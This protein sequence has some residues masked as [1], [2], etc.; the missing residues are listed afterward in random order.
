MYVNY[1]VAGAGV[2]GRAACSGPWSRT[3]HLAVAVA[4]EGE[5]S[6]SSFGFQTL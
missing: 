1:V 2:S 5:R 3:G 6:L 4:P